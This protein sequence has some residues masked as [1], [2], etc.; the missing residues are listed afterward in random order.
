MLS[1]G[2]RPPGG[3]QPSVPVRESGP[4]K[5]VP[6]LFTSVGLNTQTNLTS[7]VW[8]RY[9]LKRKC[10]GCGPL[11]WGESPKCPSKSILSFW[12]GRKEATHR[13]DRGVVSEQ[14]QARR[15]VIGLVSEWGLSKQLVSLP[16]SY[17][18]LSACLWVVLHEDGVCGREVQ[19]PHRGFPRGRTVN[20]A[21]ILHL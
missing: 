9:P 14:C 2:P 19:R 20:Q 18:S 4:E 6:L 17:P 21:D 1:G 5:R 12:E 10:I 3:P 16:G 15:L 13:V 7:C 11:T 8:R